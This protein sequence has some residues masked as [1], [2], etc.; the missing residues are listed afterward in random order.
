[1]IKNNLNVNVISIPTPDDS[2]ELIAVE[3]VNVQP[4]ITIAAC[5]KPP[6]E[7]LRLQKWNQLI[8]NLQSRDNFVLMGDFNA[9][10]ATWNC[11]KNNP[12]SNNLHALIE[13]NDIFLHNTET[14]TRIGQSV[15]FDSNIDLV[16]SS[17]NIAHL[18][19]TRQ[20]D[21]PLTSDHMP[22]EITISLQKLTY[23]HRSNR[24]STTRTD[25]EKFLVVFDSYWNYF[26]SHD[27]TSLNLEQRYDTFLQKMEKAVIDCTPAKKTTRNKSY[28]Q[29]ATWW[30]AD[31]SRA[32]RLRKAAFKKWRH[33][34]KFTDWDIY[35]KQTAICKKVLKKSKVNSFRT[36]V[37]GLTAHTDTTYFWEKIR[38]FKTKWTTDTPKSTNISEQQKALKTAIDKLSPPWVGERPIQITTNSKDNF[39]DSPFNLTE[40]NYT[41][42]TTNSRSAPGPDKIEYNMIKNL[43]TKSRLLLLD[44]LNEY[45]TSGQ[46]PNSWKLS[47]VYFIPK[48]NRANYRSITLASNMCKL[49]ERLVK[50]RQSW[51]CETLNKFNNNQSGFIKGRSCQ[52]NIGKV[53]VQAKKGLTT[54]QIIIA[55]MLDVS[56]AFDNV[57]TKILIEK[58][59]KIGIPKNTLQFIANII[60][61]RQIKIVG[62]PLL[63][64]QITHRI[65]SKGVPQGGVLS[66]LLYNLYVGEIEQN[67]PPQ[68][69]TTQYADDIAVLTTNTSIH[70][71]TQDIEKAIESI[72]HNL[73]TLGLEL[74]IPKTEIVVF[75]KNNTTS[76]P[77]NSG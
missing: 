4:T 6:S 58:L 27:F 3:I 59:T 53:I 64:G 57:N 23:S 49:F 46:I 48:N 8:E 66:L 50:N 56:S 11:N 20:H 15:Q 42:H 51:W 2:T 12:T 62:D 25:W 1:M 47:H 61:N 45:F 19:T 71:A 18:I 70:N 41:I 67:I 36:F 9:K 34:L 72:E 73:N 10:H 13:F 38:N 54:N 30:N 69:T 76:H 24:I 31:C 26:I 33:T 32:V 22:V 16:L 44:I 75:S 29:P 60:E 77:S 21:D 40:L 28:P 5:Y 37:E 63:I 35:K 14:T 39:L 7:T 55:A 52:D 17:M 65:V 68:T 43:S 74:S